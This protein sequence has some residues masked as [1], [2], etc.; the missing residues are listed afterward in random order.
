MCPNRILQMGDT[1]VDAVIVM[2]PHLV[3][4]F[5]GCIDMIGTFHVFLTIISN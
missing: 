4:S 2:S 3:L 5:P 1:V